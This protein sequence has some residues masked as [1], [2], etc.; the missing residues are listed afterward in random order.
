M[1]STSS[2]QA[3]ESGVTTLRYPQNRFAPS[4]VDG[5]GL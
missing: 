4:V 5:R 3:W 1:S 2:Q